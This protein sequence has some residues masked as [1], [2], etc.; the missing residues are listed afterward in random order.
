MAKINVYSLI[1]W[2]ILALGTL[3]VYIHV[4]PLLDQLYMH[5]LL[6]LYKLDT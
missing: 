6:C 1:N 2:H 5:I 3:S 4:D